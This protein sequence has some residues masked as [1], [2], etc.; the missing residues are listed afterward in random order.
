MASR[1]P[2]SGESRYVPRD[3]DRSPPPF[4][5]RGSTSYGAGQGPRNSDSSYRPG[6]LQRDP[7]RGPKAAQDGGRG[8]SY[9]PRGRGYAGRGDPRELREPHL[10]RRD[11]DRGEWARR[12]TFDAR[13]RRPSPPGRNRSRTPPARDARGGPRELETGR[14]PR[15][16]GPPSAESANS[17]GTPTSGGYYGRGG[18]RGRGR[19]DRDRGRGGRGDDRDSYRARSR[20]RNRAWD[21][22]FRDSRP[23]DYDR[24]APRRGSDDK[25]EP[26]AGEERPRRDPPLRPDSR[27]STG[28]HPP[29]SNAAQINAERFR[30]NAKPQAASLDLSGKASW[31]Q[32]LND[33]KPREGIK[34]HPTR[35]DLIPQTPSSPPQ[36]TQVPAFGSI[37]ARATPST[38]GA[39]Q[40]SISPK[41]EQPP[42]GPARDI[43][44]PIRAAP[45]APKA[46]L[47]QN[48]PPSGPKAGTPFQ[49]RGA[50]VVSP[51]RPFDSHHDGPGGISPQMSRFGGQTRPAVSPGGPS[52]NQARPYNQWTAPHLNFKS[53]HLDQ[54]PQRPSPPTSEPGRGSH[55]DG[56]ALPS[57]GPKIPTGPKAA[58]PS[59]RAPMGPRGF[60][61]KS[62]TWINPN[63]QQQRPSILGNMGN[64]SPSASIHRG[65][66]GEERA[67]RLRAKSVEHS[68]A[69]H[70]KPSPK[71]SIL[72]DRATKMKIMSDAD[73]M[74]VTPEDTNAQK[75]ESERVAEAVEE[76]ELQGDSASEEEDGMDLDEEDFEDAER[77]FQKDL[78]HI[79]AKRPASP[80]HHP[81]LLALLEEVDALA[82]AMEHLEKGLPIPPSEG[83]ESAPG[84][85][86]GLPS[87]TPEPVEQ[88]PVEN[89]K[90]E[91]ASVSAELALDGLPY[92]V[93]GMPTP[94]SRISDESLNEKGG[95]A[96]KSLVFESLAEDLR[97]EDEEEQEMRR[98]YIQK[99]SAWR[100]QVDI[101]D[102]QKK[103]LEEQAK[104][105]EA[106][107]APAPEPSPAPTPA[108]EGGRRN[109]AF[110]TQLELDQA[111]ALSKAEAEEKE[112]EQREREA[113]ER[114]TQMLQDET[115]EARIP[116]MLTKTE[117]GDRIFDDTNNLVETRLVLDTF[118]FVPPEDDFTVEEQRQF[119]D[120]YIKTPKKWGHIALEIP[121][122]DY[123]DCI[124]HYYLTK[125]DTAY[126]TLFSRKANRRGRKGV[127]G[128]G[129]P[130]N[131]HLMA[132]LGG[133]IVESCGDVETVPVTDTGR[134]RRAAAP[135]FAEKEKKDAEAA[136][137]KA[138]P[139]RRS[140]NA[141]KAAGE[142]PDGSAEK[143]AARRG[144][145]PGATRERAKRG[146]K[147]AVPS[148]SPSKPEADAAKSKDAKLEDALVASQPEGAPTHARLDPNQAA[149]PFAPGD[150]RAE[151]LRLDLKP[152]SMLA[153]LTGAQLQP[154]PPLPSNALSAPPPV[155]GAEAPTPLLTQ[156]PPV[157][158]P[159][160]LAPAKAETS[161][162]GSQTNSYWSVQEQNDFLTFLQ[163]FGTDWHKISAALGTKTHTMV[164]RSLLIFAVPV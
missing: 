49:R 110:N 104:A 35:Q 130:R 90:F 143:P 12:D 97:K 69:S 29:I 107:P 109:R 45:K 113:L 4:H 14:V 30:E 95:D 74:D 11:P 44:D 71:P 27:N 53:H 105:A 92:L 144:R 124:Q 161:R 128:P 142:A 164:S 120:G 18:Y 32:S 80:K 162:S 67:K 141:A 126:K 58:Q 99:F 119:T 7:P 96:V 83:D 66:P 26:W 145:Q 123:Q 158:P 138:T 25:P 84:G 50:S 36:P 152:A 8:G 155:V 156:A 15:S 134:P 63:L 9:A 87:P 43:A 129:R 133:R 81:E 5:R 16:G 100:A 21:P 73:K 111:I 61:G 86:L 62:A 68:P 42:S 31:S 64:M 22:D 20:S 117:Q 106:A 139:A 78:E 112:K 59:I 34:V 136:A 46:E 19:G 56:G 116:S 51:G 57:S 82:S 39:V 38:P 77:Q 10:G 150:L 132:D 1:F 118:G 65:P 47:N 137:P 79:Q 91:E 54:S 76:L 149:R 6:D 146:P 154:P 17:D 122:R 94:V 125:R 55:L 72:G 48:Q 13:D 159:P 103:E 28:S 102:R 33:A 121:G 89:V 75:S 93:S 98:E 24:D 41:D 157:V 127:R 108:P 147:A 148:V 37:I 60:A 2:P 40:K 160:V 163:H 114:Q 131:N 88:E 52:P 85:A 3:R 140:A 151:G 153:D 101:Y 23:R 135:N 70:L 115:K